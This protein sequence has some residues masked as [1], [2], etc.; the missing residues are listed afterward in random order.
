MS[1]IVTATYKVESTFRVPLGVPLQE[2]EGEYGT[3]WSWGVKWDTMFYFDDKGV[4]HEIEA[5]HSAS[6][7]FDYKYP[8][9][10]AIGEEECSHCWTD[11]AIGTY[12]DDE[13]A[14]CEECRDKGGY[15]SCGKLSKECECEEKSDNDE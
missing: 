11:K 15:C 5:T 7:D 13:E 4:I 1:R 9:E 2:T 6:D 3:P 12:A 14:L 8:D 10:T